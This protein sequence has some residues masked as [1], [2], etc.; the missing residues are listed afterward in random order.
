MERQD[1]HQKQQH[2]RTFVSESKYHT[3]ADETLETIQD[4]MDEL[5]DMDNDDD[6]DDNDDNVIEYEVNL[7]SGVLNI[8]VVDLTKTNMKNTWVIN[9]QT[10]NRQIWVRFF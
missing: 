9:K 10:P 2:V 3:I 8:I 5:F 7:A 1:H 6:N 4:T